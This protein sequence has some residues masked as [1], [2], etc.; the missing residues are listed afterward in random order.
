M[1]E[2]KESKIHSRGIFAT[3]N[4]KVGVKIMEITGEKISEEET[5]QRELENLK[6]GSTYIFILNDKY[7]LDGEFYGNESRYI[8]HSCNPNCEVM[9]DDENLYLVAIK[10]IIPEEELTIDYAFPKDDKIFT[11]C[12]CNSENCRGYLEE[13]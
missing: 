7:S 12:F 13:I 4:I 9:G 5:I 10:E 8:N 6:K 3:Q 11:K 1:F 2:I